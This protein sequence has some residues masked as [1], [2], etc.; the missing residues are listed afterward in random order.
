[1]RRRATLLS[2]AVLL[3]LVSAAV[4]GEPDWFT[5]VKVDGLQ[6]ACRVEVERHGR[7]VLD[8]S[9]HVGRCYYDLG[10]YEE[11]VAVYS[12]LLRS[13]DRNYA[14]AALARVGEGYFHLG[15]TAEA[16]VVFT[17]CLAMHPEAWLD[18]SIPELCR[19]WLKK[20][21]GK[22]ES[23]DKAPDTTG[24][25]DVRKEVRELEKRLAELRKLMEDLSR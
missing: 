23:P 8:D 24:I 15:R 10:R 6:A 20:L 7:G 14:A 21:E 25:E 5:R 16:K 11:G 13:P 2:A 17:R 22:L 19:A 9:L 3:L 12:R 4:A 18:G 1:M